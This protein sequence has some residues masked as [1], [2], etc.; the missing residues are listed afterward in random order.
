MHLEYKAIHKLTYRC[1]HCNKWTMFNY[2]VTKGVIYIIPSKN[3]L[4]LSLSRYLLSPITRQAAGE[5][6]DTWR[7]SVWARDSGTQ[8]LL[9]QQVSVKIWGGAGGWEPWVGAPSATEGK[10]CILTYPGVRGK[11]E[12]GIGVWQAG[13]EPRGG[14]TNRDSVGWSKNYEQPLE[15]ILSRPYLTGLKKLHL[16]P[17]DRASI[18]IWCTAHRYTLESWPCQVARSK[19]PLVSA[20][21]PGNAHL[22]LPEGNQCCP[23]VCRTLETKG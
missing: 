4:I 11:P 22:S 5:V 3:V 17:P 6:M 14:G 13:G 10:R 20:P 21:L 9:K 12:A 7:G 19:M 8:R 2:K 15:F 18:K 16:M 23:R 1:R